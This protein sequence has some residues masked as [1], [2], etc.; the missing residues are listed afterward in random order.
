[1]NPTSKW[2]K[3]YRGWLLVALALVIAVAIIIGA[4]LRDGGRLPPLPQDPQIQV[5]FNQNQ[6]RGVDY[7]DLYRQIQRPGDDLEAILLTAINGAQHRIDLA[8]QELRLPRL[9]QALVA[10]KQKGR[11]VRVILENQYNFVVAEKVG[12]GVP[13]ATSDQTG[14]QAEERL[15]DYQAFLDQNRD[16]QISGS[17][18]AERDAIQILRQGG[19]PLIDDTEDGSKGT[20]LM[21]HKFLVVD[22]QTVVVTSANFTLSDQH[23][24]YSRPATRGNA[25]NLLVIQSPALAEIFTE[26]FNLMWGDGPGGLPNSRFGINKP[27]RLAQTLRIGQST[28]TVKF[29]PDSRKLPW[30]ETSNGLIARYLN[31]AQQSVDLAL[32]VFSEQ[33]LAD[34][35][36]QPF[37]QG[38]EIKTLID[39]GFA[40]RSYSE[41]L[42]LLG[43]SLREQCRV[44]ANNR[45][46]PK[47]VAFVGIPTLIEG[48]KLHHKLAVIDDQTIITGSHN[49]SPS[50]NLQNDETLL[51]LQNSKIAAHYQRELERLQSKAQWGLPEGLQRKIKAQ[52]RA[53]GQNATPRPSPLA[54]A[55]TAPLVNLNT[56]TQAE[57][58]T[59]PGIG[60]SLAK[61]IMT[62]RQSQPFTGLE[63]LERVPGLKAKKINA[64][65]GRVIW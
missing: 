51:I 12:Q 27:P 32:F 11:Q 19:V 23:G 46:W 25:N 53:C 10:Q 38:V 2:L 63:D 17:E 45:P 22:G 65:R 13:S 26:E 48:D 1:V 54:V 58:E 62:A 34:V 36:Q 55:T 64:L 29:S 59:L 4:H 33:P 40:F 15:G 37:Q 56:A 50:A 6:A 49:W 39:P 24:D 5:Y 41:G 42:D 57:L 43:V 3:A 21:H 31:A 8:V 30:S 35:L 60:P 61:K 28:V 16:G 20:G 52:E 47:P 7:R 44:E 14:G 9:A 18:S